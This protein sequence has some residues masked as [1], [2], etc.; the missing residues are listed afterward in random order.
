MW[1]ASTSSH[2]IEGNNKNDW[3]L[4][5]D[6]GHVVGNQRSG[7]A[8]DSWNLY[9]QDH[10]VAKDLKLNTYKFSIEWSRVEPQEGSFDKKALDRYIDMVK[11][12]KSLGIEPIV[13]LHHFTNP[14]WLADWSHEGN[15]EKYARYVDY[16]VEHL[17]EHVN[18]WFTINEPVNQ[19]ILGYELNIWPPGNKNKPRGTKAFTNFSTAHKLAYKR[20]HKIYET[21]KLAR[22]NVGIQLALNNFVPSN[23]WNI[24]DQ[25][26]NYVVRRLKN[27]KFIK[28]LDHQYDILG[29]NHYFTFRTKWYSP[30]SYSDIRY[31]IPGVVKSDMGWN[32]QPEGLYNTLIEMSKYG[33]P[34]M[35]A[36]SGIADSKDDKREWFIRESLKSVARALQAGVN[37]IGYSYWSLIDN[38]EWAD[39]YEP[40]FGLASVDPKTKKRVIRKSARFYSKVASSNSL[41]VD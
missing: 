25:L 32:V 14:Q 27:H 23:R 34:I 35:V 9:K 33:V 10:Q 36:E 31:P 22:P 16:V 11:S 7:I 24:L 6:A 13:G 3:T 40:K 41:E 29:V 12:V 38:F 39:G 18:F 19:V 4:W 26:V 2:Q 5:E 1:G 20:V 30:G 8:A 21:K 15:A 37:V 28:T 17:A